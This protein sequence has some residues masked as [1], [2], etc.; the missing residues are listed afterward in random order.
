M[1]FTTVIFHHQGHYFRFQ[2]EGR[3][4]TSQVCYWQ[5]TVNLPT[6][7]SPHY[8]AYVEQKYAPY[9]KIWAEN[10]FNTEAEALSWVAN[11][12]VEDAPA[13]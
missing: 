12:L 6:A 13:I 11:H 2:R 3:Q 1:L 7:E 9:H 10:V 8:Q 4:L 5:G